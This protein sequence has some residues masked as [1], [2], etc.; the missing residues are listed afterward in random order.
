MSKTL[1]KQ[2]PS[3]AADRLGQLC[4]PGPATSLA[5]YPR[6]QAFGAG[7]GAM[8]LRPRY[9]NQGAFIFPPPLTDY[10]RR[11][12]AWLRDRMIAVSHER[13]GLMSR[14]RWLLFGS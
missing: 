5:L 9:S 4:C 7:A 8:Q 11:V 10:D 2:P 6:G 14:L 1:I 13:T 12:H 3:D